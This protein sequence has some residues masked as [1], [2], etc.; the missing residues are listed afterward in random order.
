MNR[1]VHCT[2][3]PC[4]NS[5][6]IDNSI[7]NYV[8]FTHT[9]HKVTSATAPTSRKLCFSG[10]FGSIIKARRPHYEGVNGVRM[11]KKDWQV[12]FLSTKKRWGINIPPT[13]WKEG[14]L[15][16]TVMMIAD[17]NRPKSQLLT[18]KLCTC[19]T[20]LYCW[21]QMRI[22]QML[23]YTKFNI[24]NVQYLSLVKPTVT[25]SDKFSPICFR[26]HFS[27]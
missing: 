11:W 9:L 15:Y 21:F 5:D 12:K 3:T 14:L 18:F 4:S 17:Q 13:A 2:S 25:V 23:G 7:Q 1:A 26:S 6:N 20:G 16:I 27:L 10:Y 8:Q 22:P 24:R 19:P